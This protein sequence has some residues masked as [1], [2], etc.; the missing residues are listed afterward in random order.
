MKRLSKLCLIG[1]VVLGSLGAVPFLLQL[2]E[3]SSARYETHAAAEF[4][5]AL[6]EGKWLPASLPRSASSIEEA[7]DSDTNEVWF[8]YV[9]TDPAALVPS[10]CTLVERAGI[11]A[12]DFG[13]AKGIASFAGEVE[14]ALH[15]PSG[16]FY[17]C[18]GDSYDY[19]LVLDKSS[20]RAWGWSVG[21][22]AVMNRKP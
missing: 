14:K 15:V 2:T 12:P 6:G 13:R 21:D 1:A 19:E 8:T 16:Q 4:A 9:G 17:R 11:F 10:T 20:M 7:H 3:V 18:K 22:N 5:G